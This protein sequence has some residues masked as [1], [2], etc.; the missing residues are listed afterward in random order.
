LYTI[1]TSISDD[2]KKTTTYNEIKDIPDGVI[3]QTGTYEGD[4][5]LAVINVLQG[6]GVDGKGKSQNFQADLEML[7]DL[8]TATD[9]EGNPLMSDNMIERVTEPLFKVMG[10]ENKNNIFAQRFSE[11]EGTVKLEANSFNELENFAMVTFLETIKNTSNISIT[12]KLDGIV[13]AM[14]RLNNALDLMKTNDYEGVG[15][16]KKDGKVKYFDYKDDIIEAVTKSLR[17]IT[18]AVTKELRDEYY[19]VDSKKDLT[20]LTMRTLLMDKYYG[21]NVM[22]SQLN[23]SEFA[24]NIM[25]TGKTLVKNRQDFRAKK[26]R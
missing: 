6:M 26:N 4:V 7:T 11:Q 20:T 18:K 14:E 15:V 1:E 2:G 19:G 24:D 25:E 12:K 5:T 22:N 13:I 21:S 10:D 9:A 16:S 8:L 17:P 23:D 3:G